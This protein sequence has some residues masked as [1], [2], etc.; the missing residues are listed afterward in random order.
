MTEMLPL[1][2]SRQAMGVLMR[3]L[4]TMDA[5]TVRAILSE[6]DAAAK[7]AGLPM[8]LAAHIEQIAEAK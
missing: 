2:M 7:R 3:L 6:T 4:L 5:A 8:I 1:G